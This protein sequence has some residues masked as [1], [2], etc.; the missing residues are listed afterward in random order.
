MNRFTHITHIFNLI[1]IYVYA[2]YKDTKVSIMYK[3]NVHVKHNEL[4]AYIGMY[5]P[6]IKAYCMSGILLLLYANSYYSRCQYGMSKHCHMYVHYSVL[7]I[8][9]YQ[10][11]TCC[12]VIHEIQ[13]VHV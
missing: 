6:F 7:Q 5:T 13:E 2:L 1:N 10:S 12:H 11:S 4:H 9:M 8:Q 3:S